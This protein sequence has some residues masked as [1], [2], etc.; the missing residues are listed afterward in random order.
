LLTGLDNIQIFSIGEGD[1]P[2]IRSQ[3]IGPSLGLP[4]LYFKL[5]SLNPTGSYKDRFGALAISGLVNS[6][7]RYCLATSSGN[8]GASL[9]AY[10]AVAGLPCHVVVV[11]GAPLGKLRQMQVYGAKL[12]MV[13]DFGLDARVTQETFDGLRDLATS[14]DTTVQI[15]AYAYSPFGMQGVQTLAYE[16]AEVLPEVQHVFVPAGGGGLTLA[17]AKGFEIWS[18]VERNFDRPK[19]HCVQPEGNDTIASSMRNGAMKAQAI[20]NSRTKISGLQVPGVIDGDQVLKMAKTQGGHG[21]IVEDQEVF[22]W[23]RKLAVKEGIFCEPA[24]AVAMAGLVQAMHLEEIDKNEI[25]VCLITGHGFKD[26]DAADRM[27]MQNHIQYIDN[28]NGLKRTLDE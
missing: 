17:V 22:Q 28:I 5:E 15:S 9:A 13:K 19:V 6:G 18:S 25:I 2:L 10:A 24:G 16:I 4:N 1:T 21:F 7:A 27:T 3:Q 20:A 23:Q 8:T 14:L 11:D 26:P 12:W